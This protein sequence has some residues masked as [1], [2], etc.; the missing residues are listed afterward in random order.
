MLIEEDKMRLIS[1]QK[2]DL[3]DNELNEF[4]CSY[5]KVMENEKLKVVLSENIKSYE[6]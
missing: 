5:K 6:Y 2:I 4:I 3:S 1:P